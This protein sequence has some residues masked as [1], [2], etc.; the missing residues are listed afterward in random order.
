MLCFSFGAEGEICCD[1]VAALAKSDGAVGGVLGV[2]FGLGGL[3]FMKTTKSP[4][5]KVLF[6]LGAFFLC[7]FPLSIDIPFRVWYNL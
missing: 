1:C 5:N 7:L 3:I 2:F 4:L 6:G